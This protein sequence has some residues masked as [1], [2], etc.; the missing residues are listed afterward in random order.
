M[1][2][3]TFKLR[4][5]KRT[6]GYCMK[7]RIFARKRE[8][9]AKFLPTPALLMDR[10]INLAELNGSK[11]FCDLG[12]GDGRMLVAAASRGAYAV[13]IEIDKGLIKKAKERVG[14]YSDRVD[15]VLGDI[16]YNPLIRMD[17]VYTFL[18][19]KT[20]EKLKEYF[21]EI[22][23]RGVKIISLTYK[24]P[25]INPTVILDAY[26]EEQLR[27]LRLILGDLARKLKAYKIYIYTSTSR[28]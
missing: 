5:Y 10:I 4:I 20:M 2:K 11:V 16:F 27:L 25:G 8:H 7:L 14:K 24:I 19:E 22:V 13:G 9:R 6:G 3:K 18:D 26:D 12:S 23:K 21:E 15:L 28:P 1:S 17:V